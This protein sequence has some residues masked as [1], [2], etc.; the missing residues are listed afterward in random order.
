VHEGGVVDRD[1]G[2]VV[3]HRVEDV[4]VMCGPRSRGAPAPNRGRLLHLVVDKLV[5]RRGRVDGGRPKKEEAQIEDVTSKLNGLLV[6]DGLWCA[7]PMFSL[8]VSIVIPDAEVVQRRRTELRRR[9]TQA[10][11]QDATQLKRLHRRQEVK[12]AQNSIQFASFRI[13]W[14]VVEVRSVQPFWGT[15]HS[16]N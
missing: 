10:R 13:S 16:R 11:T 2:R 15:L 3:W 12:R 14:D 5:E 9:R 7:R 1:G 4:A 8:H 6:L